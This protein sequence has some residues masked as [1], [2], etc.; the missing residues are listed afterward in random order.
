M[1]VI[2]DENFGSGTVYLE[3]LSGWEAR[4]CLPE[5]QNSKALL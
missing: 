2:H 5:H 4:E 3:F 1:T